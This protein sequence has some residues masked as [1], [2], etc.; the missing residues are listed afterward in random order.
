MYLQLIY[1]WARHLVI[2]AGHTA[3]TRTVGYS[4]AS[5][6][7]FL[8]YVH[9]VL[10]HF[11]KIKR[12][13]VSEIIAFITSSTF[14]NFVATTMSNFTIIIIIIIIISSVPFSCCYNHYNYYCLLTPT[15]T[16]LAQ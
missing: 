1:M 5:S 15:L 7:H 10:V 2:A 6:C 8:F 14:I 9:R 3:S 12:I 11:D 4:M 13:Q 16:K